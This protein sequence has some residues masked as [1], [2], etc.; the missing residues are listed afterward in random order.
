MQK[1]A[2][3]NRRQTFLV[4][5]HISSPVYA[6]LK[7]LRKYHSFRQW[8]MSHFD[9]TALQDMV[10]DG[11][12]GG[13]NGLI[14]YYETAALYLKFSDEIWELLR[15]DAHDQGIECLTLIRQLC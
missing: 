14:Y 1:P 15:V 8:M 5:A 13:F 10:R 9:R 7:S 2:K 4:T 11:V 3:R 6:V 12:G